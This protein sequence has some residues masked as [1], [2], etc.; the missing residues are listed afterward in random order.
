M[1]RRYG[2]ENRNFRNR[3]LAKPVHHGYAY[4]LGPLVA[5]LLAQFIEFFDRLCKMSEELPSLSLCLSL[6][7]SITLLSER[8]STHHRFVRFVLQPEHLLP[9][10]GVSCGASERRYSPRIWRHHFSHH[11]VDVNWRVCKRYVI[12]QGRSC[13]GKGSC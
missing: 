6:S 8:W 10:K 1:W 11:F 13:G 3:N 5:H 4:D 12:R 9:F 2:D 7:L